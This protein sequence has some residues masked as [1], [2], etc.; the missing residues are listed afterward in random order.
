MIVM[1]GIALGKLLY[2][3]QVIEENQIDD[4]RYALE[5][6]MSEFLEIAVI[7]G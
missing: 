7:I 1:I 6:M 3:H 4:I 2:H 5:I